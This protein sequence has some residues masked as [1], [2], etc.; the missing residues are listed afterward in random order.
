MQNTGLN[1][2]VRAGLLIHRPRQIIVELPELAE[3]SARQARRSIGGETK[4][5]LNSH[6]RWR[7]DERARHKA[8][9]A[10]QSKATKLID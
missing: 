4:T 3:F 8:G 2:T 9:S 7:M 10:K 5:H 1:K 6:R